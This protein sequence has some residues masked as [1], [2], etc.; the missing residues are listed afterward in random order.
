MV[1]TQSEASVA[2]KSI[3]SRHTT[4]KMTEKTFAYLDKVELWWMNKAQK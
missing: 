3:K 2:V 1:Y 4:L